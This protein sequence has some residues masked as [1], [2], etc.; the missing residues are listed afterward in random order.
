MGMVQPSAQSVQEIPRPTFPAYWLRFG[1][2]FLFL[3]PAFCVA[4]V[5]G[6]LLHEVAGHGLAALLVGGRFDG[7][8][9]GWNGG[10]FA[11]AYPPSDGSP[12]LQAVV[13]GGGI[14]MNLLVGSIVLGLSLRTRRLFLRFT[15]ILF[16]MENLLLTVTYGLWN[17]LWPDGSGDV[18]TLLAIADKTWLRWTVFAVSLLV[19]PAV[20]IILNAL[21]FRGVEEWLGGGRRL[22]GWRRTLPLAALG[23]AAAPFW[24]LNS[25]R[26]YFPEL[27]W[28]PSITGASLEVLVFA[29]L[30]RFSLP[31][32]GA[33]LDPS[34]ANLPILTAI[35]SA[36][37]ILGASFLTK[38]PFNS[39]EPPS[40]PVPNGYDDLIAASTMIKKEAPDEDAPRERKEEF[41]RDGA[42]ALELARRGL[43]KPCG[44]PLIPRESS[45]MTDLLLIRR[46]ADLIQLEA[47]LADQP[48]ECM[49]AAK[50]WLDLLRLDERSSQGGM[51]VH[52]LVSL[53]L[54]RQ[55]IQGLRKVSGRLSPDSC[56]SA[57]R[58][59]LALESE[60]EDTSIVADRDHRFWGSKKRWS[61]LFSINFSSEENAWPIAH[62]RRGHAQ[63]L[64]L[65]L[66][67]A[68]RAFHGKVGRWPEHLDELAPEIL[69]SIPKDP[70]GGEP[71]VYRPQGDGYLL[72]SVGVDGKDD[73]GRQTNS[74]NS[75]AP[76]DLFLEDE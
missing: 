37:L 20:T 23:I 72:Y 12:L 75:S 9:I 63:H 31:P 64:L 8:A 3:I 28:V 70:F 27:A 36:A 5:L 7:F 21:L 41:L 39:F 46:L 33:P 6:V 15:L 40:L 61:Y 42:P 47:L 10:A 34:A 54:G 66:D 53:A 48:G 74:S 57:A 62:L 1:V 69:T 68:L 30:Y 17:S 29:G 52:E 35:G 19:F 44:V 2:L 25:S 4:S 11:S 51:V 71:F 32:K 14:A 65:A 60:H 49:A 24:I 45:L 55:A 43:A 58:L 73:G 67:L 16:A 18:G 38:L 13:S 76:S 59:V 22:E 26:A 56:A 50:S